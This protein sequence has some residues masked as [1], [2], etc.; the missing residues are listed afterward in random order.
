MLTIDELYLQR[1]IDLALLGKGK[2]APNPMVGAVLVYNQRII[3]EGYHQQ[4]GGAHAEVNCMNNVPPEDRYLIP[5]ATMY[6]SLEP[7]NH[8]GKTPPCTNFIIQ[9]QLKKV[10]IGCTDIFDKVNGSGIATLQAAG[11]EVIVNVL[12]K[13]CWMLNKYFFTFHE[14]KRP[15]II[16]KWAQTCNGKIAN[17]SANRLMISN[18]FTNIKMH[19]LRSEVAAILVG[20]NTALR[21]NP[22]LNNRYWQEGNP[23]I[24]LVIDKHLQLNATSHLLNQ[25]QTTLVFNFI[26]NESN[27]NVSYIQLD[28]AKDFLEQLIAVCYQKNIQ[29]IMVEGGAKTLQSFIDKH[30]WD[31][32]CLITNQQLNVEGGLNAP[33]FSG[34]LIQEETI[35]SDNIQYFIPTLS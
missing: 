11:L 15:Y 2:V 3:A 33:V 23:P 30:L 6:V 13:E 29:S 7:C 10:V 34:K 12:Q 20:T 26:K 22:M 9:H 16:L 14:K 24:R 35:F 8:Y 21:D 1:C 28:T 19:Q 4:F 32:A 31:E 18:N 27:K 5:H 25:E 17:T